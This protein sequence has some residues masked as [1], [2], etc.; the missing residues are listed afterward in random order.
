MRSSVVGFNGTHW[1]TCHTV[2]GHPLEEVFVAIS[3]FLTRNSLEV[4]VVELTHLYNAEDS[5]L[6]RLGDMVTRVL[7]PLIAPCCEYVL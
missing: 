7:G 1:V 2:E 6:K 3:N 4:V 5:D